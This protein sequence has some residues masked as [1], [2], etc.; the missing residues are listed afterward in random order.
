MN[1]QDILSK[2]DSTSGKVITVITL[3]SLLGGMAWSF[4]GWQASLVKQED[5]EK[6]VAALELQLA[7]IATKTEVAIL[8]NDQAIELISVSIMRYEDEL[9]GLQFLVESGEA[10]PMDRVK[11]QNTLNRLNSLKDKLGRLEDTA[12]E[13]Q[14]TAN[15]EDTE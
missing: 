8:L 10:T 13:L 12:A 5:L 1:K 4:F 11:Y 9:V 6:E 7:D 14:R 3:L 2:L 15:K